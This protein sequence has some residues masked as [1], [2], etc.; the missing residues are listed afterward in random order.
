MVISDTAVGI[1]KA[2]EAQLD[3][4]GSAMISG[5]IRT[6]NRPLF[7]AYQ[8]GG[9]ASGNGYTGLITFANI[10]YNTGN[11]YNTSTG[12]FTAPE[13]GYYW[14]YCQVLVRYGTAAGR[15]EMSFYI[16]G[17][18]ASTRATSYGYVGAVGDHNHMNFA[19]P[20]FLNAGDSVDPRIAA[21]GSGVNIFYGEDLGYFAGFFIG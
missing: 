15:I 7:Y 20:L 16:N 4:R 17:N 14:L 18:I 13:D 11:C 3:V 6:P 21:A 12:A 9:A 10:R 19:V 8:T 1:G 5:L 2:P